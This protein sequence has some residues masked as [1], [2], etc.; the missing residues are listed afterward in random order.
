MQMKRVICSDK[1]GQTRMTID[2]FK[3]GFSNDSLERS[4]IC[5]IEKKTI[6]RKDWDARQSCREWENILT[7]IL[8]EAA[9]NLIKPTSRESLC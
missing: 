8:W 5:C 9:S 2:P 7:F 3:P 4:F 1:G 6:N